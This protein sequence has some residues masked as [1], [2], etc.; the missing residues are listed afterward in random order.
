MALRNYSLRV[1][2]AAKCFDECRAPLRSASKQLGSRFFTARPDAGDLL[3]NIVFDVPAVSADR[4]AT[5]T[6]LLREARQ[7]LPSALHERL[8]V[9]EA[10]NR[11]H[12]ISAQLLED[13]R[14][15]RA[16]LP[17]ALQAPEDL[18]AWEAFLPRAQP[19]G[20]V[21]LGTASGSFAIWL[22]ER[23]DWFRT[24]D[25]GR[26][27]Q[28][29][30]GFVQLDVWAQADEIRDLISEAPRPFVLYCDN[31]DKQLE[32]KTF[33]PALRIGDFL[34]VHDLGTEV[35]EENIPANFTERL[36]FGLTGF[37]EKVR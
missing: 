30:P 3:A 34:A 13:K 6:D 37:Y 5:A 29:T 1:L 27:N 4:S 22:N 24:I 21:E 36:N 15:G 33:A 14:Q 26:P 11:P 10:P 35:F 23:V 32:V 25:I 17:G 19:R 20:L 16:I 2:G 18:E 28:P 12:E 7:V 31:G 9:T 8:V